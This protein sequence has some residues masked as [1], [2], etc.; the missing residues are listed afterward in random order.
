[1]QTVCYGNSAMPPTT[2]ESP[3]TVTVPCRAQ[4]NSAQYALTA[5]CLAVWSTH[6]ASAAPTKWQRHG[7]RPDPPVTRMHWA[8]GQSEAYYLTSF[9]TANCAC[10]P[11]TRHLLS[12]PTYSNFECWQQQQQ[13]QQELRC[14][15]ASKL[16]ALQWKRLSCQGAQGSGTAHCT[17]SATPIPPPPSP[18]RPNRPHQ[19]RHFTTHFS[20]HT[21]HITAKCY[22]LQ[23]LHNI[24]RV[25]LQSATR[26]DLHSSAKC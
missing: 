19:H 26:Q 18:C 20:S 2:H 13:Q 21:A 1:M 16:P 8:P 6:R 24:R 23:T 7:P 4:L 5:C 22:W 14:R 3:S 10:S 11:G 12:L 25:A 17:G 15:K 9:Q